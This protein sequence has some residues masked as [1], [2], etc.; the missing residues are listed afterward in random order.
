MTPLL[1]AVAD[2]PDAVSLASWLSVLFYLGG[3]ICTV[4]GGLWALKEIRKP[5]APATPQP[6]EVKAHTAAASKSEIDQLHGRIKREREELDAQLHELR[7]ENRLLRE[8]LDDEISALQDRIDA[9]P[10]RVIT[11]LRETKGLI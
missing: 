6:F 2:T 11:L 3:F 1:I 9:V 7:A 8:K 4:L 10:Q 5:T